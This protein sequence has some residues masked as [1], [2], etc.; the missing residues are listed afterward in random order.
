MQV[1]LSVVLRSAHNDRL[2]VVKN[3]IITLTEGKDPMAKA[4]ALHPIH[5]KETITPHPLIKRSILLSSAVVGL[6]SGVAPVYAQNEGRT[7]TPLEEVVVTARRRE[8]SLQEIPV[9][10]TALSDDFLRTQSI[11][12]VQD[13]GIKVP[14]LRISMAGGSLSEPLITLRGQR[15]GEA[16][17]NQDAAVPMY[18]NDIVI[19]PL[20]GSN[21]GI[22]DL[23]SL[24][25]LKGPQGTLFGRNSTGGAVLLSPKQPSQEFGGYAEVKVGDYDLRTFEGA[26]DVPINDAWAMRLAGRK[27]DRD[28]Y[29]ENIADNALRGRDFRDEHS[30]SAR[31]S[32]SFT[33]ERLTNLAVFSYDESEN[34]AA[35][36]VTNGINYSIGL[37]FSAAMSPVLAP[38]GK[39]VEE[40][41]SRDD[42]WKVKT[43]VA[44]KEI[45]RNV[46][47]SSTTE[48]EVNDRLSLKNIIGYR[49]VAF[50]SATDID[51]TEYPVFGALPLGG[52]SWA[53]G[54]PWGVT[55]DPPMSTM[56]S[57]FFSD[58]M[59]LMGSAFEDKLDWITGLYWSQLKATQ[60]RLLQQ[61]PFTYDASTTD[62]VNGSM[63]LFAEGSYAFNDDWS[64]TVG[65]RQ[66]WEEREL[67]VSAWSDL[68]RTR[69][70][71]QGPG[72][73][74]LTTCE[75][76][77]DE[78]FSSTTWRMSLSYTPVDSQLIY[79]SVSTGYR[80]GGFNTRG[81]DDATLEPFEE[82]NVLTYEVGHKADWS[83]GGMGLR[84][85]VAIYLQDY[86][87]IQ[88]TVSF[89]E[90]SKLVTRTE[91][92]AEAEIFGLEAELTLQAT[93]NLTMS[94][95][96]SLVD[97]EYKEREDLIG[98]V[99]VD[100]TNAPFSYLPEQ[101]LTA[102]ASYILPIDESLGEMS[103]MLS[104]YWQDTMITHPKYNQ[105][106]IL[107][108]RTGGTWADSDLAFARDYSKIDAYTIWNARFDWR[109]VMNSSFDL[110]VFVNNATDEKYVLGGLNVLDSGGYSAYHYGDPRTVGASVRYSF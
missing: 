4:C 53:A 52:M 106:N 28:G 9:A 91:N 17:F 110:A 90:D 78:S 64:L 68:A 84:S 56:D 80:A 82:E 66:S 37:G 54:Q 14:S 20:Q 57:E 2:L 48:F 33:G 59:Q 101:T 30:E 25:V 58:E 76:E 43:D 50:K 22:Y 88:N 93:D 7:V 42:P 1:V 46:F 21:L 39:S 63:G 83:L 89:F 107:P 8:E 45:V 15:Q 97:A 79:G 12:Q 13:L 40:T 44:S 98:T 32:L 5:S 105:F 29:Q 73:A 3:I 77:V 75:R 108:G 69:C 95:S 86:T 23:Q 70:T 47:V 60:D 96:Y 99:M 74:T 61:G 51:G 27:I 92:A 35:V 11:A 102:S 87:D 109:N 71:I 10:V 49:K 16:G 62:A 41:I 94:L 103:V 67:T 85:N 31:L 6:L 18:F 34:A 55:Y 36:P 38:W 24:Q 104:A 72:G 19:S 81:V 65:V 26:V 100:T